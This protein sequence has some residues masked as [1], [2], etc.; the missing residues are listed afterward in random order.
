M[1]TTGVSD[2]SGVRAAGTRGASA[3][4]LE[5]Q[6]DE[7]VEQAATSASDIAEVIRLYYRHVPPED[8]LGTDP[9]TLVGMVRAHLR[10]AGERVLGRPVINVINPGQQV[11]GWSC[12]TTVV[13]IVTDDMPYL[14]DSVA[15]ELARS[16]LDVEQIVHPIVVVSRD[17]SGALIEVLP[18]ADV[19]EPPEGTETESWMCIQLDP[20]GDSERTSE[21]ENRLDSVISDVREVVEDTERMSATVLELA[22][23]LEV[24]PPPLAEAEVSDGSALLR[25]LVDGHFTFLGYRRYEVVEDPEGSGNEPAL[26]AALASGLGVLRRDSVAARSLTAGPDMAATA[27]APTLLVLTPASA[28]STVHRPVRPYYI[29]VKTFDSAGRVTGE[30]RFLGM[31]TTS[32]L[33][34]DVLDIPVV[35]RMVRE[36]IRRAGFPLQS[37][38]G[39]R[40]LEVLQEWP[41]AELFSTDLESLYTMATGAITLADRRRLRLFLRRDPYH[42]FYSCLVFVPRDRY[43]TRSRTAMQDVLLDEL[44]GSEIEFSTRLGE[45][46]LAQVHFTVYTEQPGAEEPDTVRI[47]ERLNEAVRGWEDRLVEALLQQR[48]DSGGFQPH[49]EETATEQAQRFAA[50]LPEAYKEDF[51]AA[52][53]LADL[54]LLDGLSEQRDVTMR[55]Y[56]PDGGAPGDSRFKIYLAG[57]GV[58]LSALLPMLQ[59]MGVEVIDQRPYEIEGTSGGRCWIYDFGLRI[60]STVHDAVLA[61]EELGGLRDRFQEAFAAAWHGDAEIDGFNGLVLWA[62]LTWRQVA[63]LRAYARYLRQAGTPY[64]QTYIEDA[65]LSHSAI[66]AALVALF[67]TKFDPRSDPEERAG[68]VERQQRDI[69]SMIDAVTSLDEDRILRGLLTVITATLRTNYYVTGADGAPCPYLSVKLEPQAVPELPEPRPQYEIYVYSPRTEGVHLRFG[70]VARGGIRWSDR[71]EDFRTEV[72]GLVKAQAVKNAVI[73]PVGAKGGFIVKNPPAPTGDR[74]HD[75]RAHH[76]EGVACY[77]MFISGLLELTDNLDAGAIVPP[78]DVVRYDDDDH[79]LVV[80]ADK[81]TATFSD[82]ANDVSAAYGFWLGDAFASGGSAGY[83]HKAMGITAKGAWESVKRHFRELGVD[84]QREEFTV[85]GIGD[86]SGDVFGNGMLLSEH[87]RLVAAFNHLHIFIDPEPDAAWSF[88]ERQRLFELPRSSW[89]DYDRSLISTGGGVFSRD[90]K[91]IAITPQMRV[92][93]GLGDEVTQLTPTELIRAILCAPVGLLF[94]GGIGTYVKAS[95]ESHADA[96]DKSN[97][98]VRVDGVDLRA[99][100][101]GEGGNL[102]LTQ[103]GRIE[104]ARNGGKINTDALDNS[105]GV[106][107]SDHEV[108]Y[109]ILLEQIITAGKLARSERDT[110]LESMTSDVAELVLANNYRQN[111]VLGVSRRHA[112]PM[113][114]VHQRQVSFLEAHAGLDRELEVLPS[115]EEFKELEKAGEGLS[116]PELASLLAHVKLQLEDEL[117]A[118]ELPDLEVFQRRLPGY[119]PPALRSRFGEEIHAHPLNR[120][121]VTTLLV[122][123]VVDGAGL[124]YAFRLHEEMHATSTDAVRAFAVVTAVYELPALW[125][126]IDELDNVVATEVADDMML[127]T[128]RL[129]DRASRWWLSNRPQPL[130]VGSEIDRFAGTVGR[131]APQVRRFLRGAQ[132]DAV[133]VE[134]ERLR[135]QGVPEDVADRVSVLLEIYGLLDITE[136]AEL[137][138]QETGVSRERSPEETAELYYA[139]SDHLQVNALLTSVSALERGNRWHALARLALRDDIYYSLRA[140]TLDALRHSNPGD[141]VDDKIEQ[142]ETVNA[143]RLARARVALDEINRAGGLDLATLSVAARQMRSMSG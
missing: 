1:T 26:R 131:L 80:A 2:R 23:E 73:V 28:P 113:V 27:L 97:D 124:S 24:S 103:R 18:H 133:S 123:E 6:R 30:H 54:Q 84:T 17:V 102:G 96:D 135:A 42:R 77:R 32:A 115:H 107:T 75:R 69:G 83:D 95:S 16:G 140:I 56:V 111:K 63:V 39:Q 104:F 139:L 53:G 120:A 36:V 137:A 143:S 49:A 29:G 93:L 121:I 91:S 98:A 119:F 7:L 47:Q 66:A 58:T 35:E 34:A 51:S 86:M 25:W 9:A 81:G 8:I 116:S 68:E 5:Q 99:E 11:D 65:L 100:V 130:A 15:A 13:Q 134:Y 76:D 3:R 12:E 38:S 125:R 87:I 55:F 136:V 142:W 64:S 90:A 94:N 74:E 109:K 85:V 4:S 127:E 79:Y 72:L 105:A 48:R 22:E 20:L 118:S 106:D 21:L 138:E 52:D 50:R 88:R 114:S 44:G 108:N 141:P 126:R 46:V 37:H 110:L 92:T 71:R 78:R 132:A 57:E 60:D 112:V 122:N 67:E 129:L 82:I 101:V 70:A 61:E 19:D 45:T 117:L 43:S 40:M 89:E 14:V 128:R 10:L 33:H 62:G 41:R 59:T 31:F